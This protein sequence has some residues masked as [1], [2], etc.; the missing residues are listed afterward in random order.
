MYIYFLSHLVYD[1]YENEPQMIYYKKKHGNYK[2]TMVFTHGYYS[3]TVIKPWLSL[4]EEMGSV[5][6]IIH[7]ITHNC[8]FINNIFKHTRH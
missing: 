8:V 3:F 7:V 1:P 2:L 5:T 6:I 4:D